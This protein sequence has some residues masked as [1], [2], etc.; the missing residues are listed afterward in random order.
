LLK[1]DTK[2]FEEADSREVVFGGMGAY[3]DS[4]EMWVVDEIDGIPEE[5]TCDSQ[6]TEMTE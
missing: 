1:K 3:S 2:R 5:I 4:N 6:G